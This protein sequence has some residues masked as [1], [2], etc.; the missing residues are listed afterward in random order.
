MPAYKE[1]RKIQIPSP[2]D[3]SKLSSIMD[4]ICCEFSTRTKSQCSC[5][6]ATIEPREY[7]S[8]SENDASLSGQE[9]EFLDNNYPLA[10]ASSDSD[11]S[12]DIEEANRADDIAKMWEECHF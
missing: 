1:F 4:N 5:H 11:T 6:E 8:G 9:N 3:L 2:F 10:L 7:G 12:D